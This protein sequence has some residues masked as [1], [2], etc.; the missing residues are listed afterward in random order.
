MTTQL[1]EQVNSIFDFAVEKGDLVRV[2]TGEATPHKGLFRSDTGAC[3]GMACK[4]GYQ[5]HT[6]SDVG[7]LVH[8]A[9]AAFRGECK[10]DTYFSDGH[11]V[12]VTPSDDYRRSIYGSADSIFPRLTIRARYDGRGFS[13]ALAYY[14]DAC[15]NLAMLQTAGGQSFVSN[16]RHS[17]QMWNRIEELCQHYAKLASGWENV[18][19]IALQMQSKRVKLDEFLS[20]VYPDPPELSPV[21]TR[22]TAQKR[23]GSIFSRLQR[24]Q[25]QTGRPEIGADW[26]VSA[27]EAFNAVQGYVQH[28]MNRRGQP[29]DY[30][31]SLKS[32]DDPSVKLALE[33]AIAG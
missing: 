32:L 21:R 16:I 5:P 4:E 6:T 19:E 25:Q 8:A 27:W 1:V 22:N 11:Y 29:N 24:E 33:L 20:S 17:S 28:D 30:A 12:T 31:R 13:S 7:A 15:K 3:V 14:R 2:G 23:I 26:E 18:V 9:S 10:I